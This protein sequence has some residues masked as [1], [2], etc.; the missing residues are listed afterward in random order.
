MSITTSARVPCACGAVL[1]IDVVDSLNAERH[2]HLRQ[3][4]LER[5]LHAGRCACGRVVVAERDFLYVDLGRRQVLGVFPRDEGGVPDAAARRLAAA[6]ERWFLTDAPAWV[7]DTAKHCLV[8]ACFGLEELREKLVGDDARLDDLAV[9]IVKCIVLAQGPI[10]RA[11][12][13][14]ALR[15]DR[16]RDD[17]DLELLAMDLDD[18]PLGLVTRVLRADLDAIAAR[19]TG[20]LLAAYPGIAS[21]PHVSMLRLARA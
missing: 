9:E 14:A 11:A 20:E 2:P 5:Q 18:Q 1:S 12:T 7:R 17:G 19:P 13:V 15:L 21:G 16:V 4:I 10:Y 3:Q 8:R 6:Y